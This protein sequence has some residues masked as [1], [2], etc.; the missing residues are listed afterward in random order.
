MKQ[1]KM[2]KINTLNRSIFNYEMS[3]FA[4][5]IYIWISR[6]TYLWFT[7]TD[8]HTYTLYIYNSLPLITQDFALLQCFGNIIILTYQIINIAKRM[9]TLK[10]NKYGLKILTP[11]LDSFDS[12]I[13]NFI[14][15]V[16]KNL[17]HRLFSRKEVEKHQ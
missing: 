8:T 10:S 16:R 11:S 13:E 12:Q 4:F 17:V 3:I 15:I 2:K 9:K 7:H 14:C 5:T 1:R 6:I